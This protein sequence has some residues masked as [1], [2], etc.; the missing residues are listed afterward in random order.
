M[1]GKVDTLRDILRFHEYRYYV[2]N[3]PLIS[4]FEY[5]SL[6]KSKVGHYRFAYTKG[7]Q[8]IDK[9]F[10]QSAAPSSYAL[11]RKFIQRR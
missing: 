7:W 8:G 1:S 10:S 6:Y 3:D 5:D 9:G 11:F 4:D 2:Q